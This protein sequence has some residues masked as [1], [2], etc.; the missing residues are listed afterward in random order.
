MNRPWNRRDVLRSLSVGVIAGGEL[1][2]TTVKASVAAGPARCTVFDHRGEPLKPKAFD[3]FHLC[4]LLLRPFTIEPQFEPGTAVFQPP[5]EPFRIALPL[6]V[7]G[8]GQVFVYADNRGRGYTPQSFSEKPLALNYEFAAD[9]LATVHKLLE[10]CRRAGITV[11]AAAQERANKA[12][13]LLDRAD[14][15]ANDKSAYAGALASSL[16]ESLWAGEMIVIERAEAMIARRGPRPGFLF[17]CDAFGHPQHGKPYTEQFEALFNYA[18]LPFYETA[19]ES[20][21]GRPDYGH[22]EE[23]AKWLGPKGIIMKGHPLIFLIPQATP[24][25]MR[26]LSFEKTKEICLT[27]VRRSIQKFRDRI[28]IW[29]VINEAHVQPDLVGNPMQMKGFTK[30]QNVELTGAALAAARE[31]DPTCF[32]VVNSTG[33][34]CDYY[35]GRKPA[36]WQQSVYDYLQKL[37]DAG[38]EY[39]VVGLQYYHSGRDLVEFERNVESFKGF[40]KRIHLTELG[41]SSSSDNADSD[42]WWGGGIGGAKLVWRGERFTEEL[43]AQWAESVYKIAYSKPYVDAVTWWDFTDP[44][45][46]P[47]GGLLRADCTPKLAYQRLMALRAKWKQA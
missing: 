13:A 19:V 26:D 42:P 23:I 47:N 9:R 29:D 7:P 37:K 21:Q 44:G 15:L 4:D 36:V 30:E 35:M 20:V 33:T 2:A 45:F 24:P 27:H 11:S 22:A 34:W 3:R 43:Q 46:P 28:H 14:G 17:G 12:K 31:A 18:T 5:K 40:G 10:E 41:F 1:L 32:R 25:W 6:S 16:C 38:F 8:F 39:E